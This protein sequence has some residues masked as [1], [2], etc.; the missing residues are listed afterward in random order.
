MKITRFIFPLSALLTGLGSV[1]I[2]PAL[3]KSELAQPV[4][5]EKISRLIAPQ[6]PTTTTPR[7]HGHSRHHSVRKS[8]MSFHQ[9]L[10]A[11]DLKQP[12]TAQTNLKD[13][14]AVATHS[15]LANNSLLSQS[16]AAVACDVNAF[17]T[18][19]ST[20]L[21]NQIKTQG[22]TCV[23]ELF[24][25][26]SSVQV[27]AYSSDNM[28][29]VANHV[30]GLSSSYNG[31]GDADIEAMFLYL[32][33]G[34]YVE[35]YNDGVSFVSW[36]KPAVKGAIDAFVNNSHFY[37]DNDAHGKTLAEVIIT[38]DS[39]EQQ[40]VYIGVAKNWLSRW[41]Q[42]YANKWNMRNAI[43]GFFTLIFRGQW[44]SNF[45]N[46]V[47]SDTTLVTRLR[48]FALSS[49]MV[50]TDAE[51]MIANAGGELGRLKT[52]SG[53]SI[54]SSVDSALNRVFSTYQMVGT[55]DAVW[56][57]A[58]DTAEYYG[59]CADY[60]ICGFAQKVEAQVLS[61]SHTCSS[62]IKIRSQNMTST[63]L[64]SACQ[65]MGFE[66]TLFHNQ[67][68]TN[69]T[70]VADD[71]NAF[72]QVNIF[73]SDT[74]YGKYAKAIFKIN[75]NNGGMYLEG[76]PSV[77]GN[78]ANFVAYEATYA[79]ADHYVWN[80]EHEYVHYLDGRF[81]LYGDFNAPTERTVWWTEGVAEY[82]SKQDDN[83]AAIDTIKDGSTYTLGTIFET[84]YDGFDQDR[85][86]RWGYLAVRFMFERHRNEV[87]SMLASTRAGNWT[88]YKSRLNTWV[89]NYSNEFTQ[90]TQDLANGTGGNKAPTANVNGPYTGA[91]GASINFSSAGSA[92]TDG[93]ITSYEWTFG[94]GSTSTSANPSHQYTAV[95]DYEV[96][97]T[98]TD[99]GGL[100]ASAK[101]TARI[102]SVSNGTELANGVPMATQG[103]QG[104]ENFFTMQV[105][106]NATD[107]SFSISG[108][109]GDADLY[110]RFGN[111]PT[112]QTY[113]CRPWLNGNNETC[114]ISNV[115]AGTY[116]IMIAGYNAYDTSLTG[117]Y[118]AKSG[119]NVPNACST[120]GPQTGGRL[121]DG[122]ATCLGSQDPMWFSLA[123][124]SGA[125]SIAIST[126]NGSGDIN[127]EYS[128]AGWP[129]SSNV[130][131]SS[132]NSGNGECIVISN[133]S[134]YWGYLKVSGTASGAS[135]VVDYNATSCR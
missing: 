87:D 129:N 81:D 18:S 48:D 34:Y 118:T 130:Q 61:Q 132:T 122:T 119:S 117:S 104:S 71:F 54:Q 13:P 57:A 101:T 20:T 24:S 125:T 75:T 15:L 59:N 105:P 43:N 45:V 38:M 86:Y 12:P 2:S 110:V 68:A 78:Q 121:Q 131:A 70:P 113:D 40:D 133:Q 66:E 112:Q 114:T 93:T 56:L 17:A 134:Q 111:K 37:D 96:T 53:T 88:A 73:D 3:A 8:D 83:Q 50:G 31:G 99:N 82:V 9:M 74:D 63:Q 69:N 27:S 14:H 103:A 44:N 60:N 5:I 127:L 97:L 126:G 90:W 6:Q 80:L 102:D 64:N 10:K 26:S 7:F 29:A 120:S 135:I 52:Y 41:N 100:R 1:A 19:N 33:A 79:N 22:S 62:T 124:V 109:S 51:F 36:V 108:G 123:D 107:L 115:Q 16:A 94:D 39:S 76:D 77:Q 25:A 30:K 23:N 58:A 55:G 47:G 65:K 67:L 32:R 84:T 49:W 95:G 85:I 92:D 4:A 98:V 116:H 91:I 11:D 42:S 21:I 72:L 46:Q 128:N 35:F 89:S 106:A 28:Y